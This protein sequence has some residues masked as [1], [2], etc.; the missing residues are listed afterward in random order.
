MEAEKRSGT[1]ET[2]RSYETRH[3]PLWPVVSRDSEKRPVVYPQ[4]EAV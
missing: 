1:T 4:T 3:G 2:G